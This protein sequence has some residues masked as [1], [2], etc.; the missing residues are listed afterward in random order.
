M[1]T[2]IRI[3]GQA[4]SLLAIFRVGLV[5]LVAL[6]GSGLAACT[7]SEARS[8]AGGSGG[9]GGG[10]SGTGGAGGY[11]PNDGLACLPI[12]PGGVITD[13]TY[14]AG[15]AVT[16]QV[17]F[18][19]LATTLTGGQFVYPNPQQ[20]PPNMYPLI[21]NMTE[22]NWHIT[23]MVG[24]YS[25]FGLYFSVAVAGVTTACTRVDATGY[26]GISFTVSGSVPGNSLTFEVDTLNDT[27][28]PAWLST[29]M[30]S[31][32]A[33][34]SG[35]CVPGPT[36]V[37]Q[38][39]QTDCVQPTKAVAV[40]ATPTPVTVLW[41]DFTTGK[42]DPAPKATDIVSIRWVLPNPPGVA[43]SGVTPYALDITIDDL[44]FVQ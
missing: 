38:Y 28:V 41:S 16:D 40:T 7:T 19:D 23:G 36:A 4:R 24:D 17:P 8:D 2:E 5:A 13:F 31:P 22:N 14:T 32:M 10:G 25:G 27:I 37:N 1:S 39:A 26:R 44:K 30:G 29:H 6:A 3:N 21:S 35:R 34:D 42:P 43:T 11:A 12:A 15:A 33:T 9:A 18:G 20:Q